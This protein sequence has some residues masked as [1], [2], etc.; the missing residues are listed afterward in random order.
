V[1][2]FQKPEDLEHIFTTQYVTTFCFLSHLNVIF[3]MLFLVGECIFIYILYQNKKV[4]YV[5]KH[6]LHLESA[7]I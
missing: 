3:V 6:L 1:C 7:F 5:Q 4:K 2:F